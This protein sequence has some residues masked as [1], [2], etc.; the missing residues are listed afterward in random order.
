MSL[1]FNLVFVPLWVPSMYT[2]S[3]GLSMLM[4]ARAPNRG[5]SIMLGER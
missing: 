3:P 5:I 4:G 1:N 2:T